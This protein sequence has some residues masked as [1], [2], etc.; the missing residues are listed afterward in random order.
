MWQ[1][2]EGNI[3]GFGIGNL[4]ATTRGNPR[5][6]IED[7]NKIDLKGIVRIWTELIWLGA[8]GKW[9]VVDKKSYEFWFG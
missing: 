1:I 4:R 6:K 5:R 8:N 2:R 9:R 3:K 7:N